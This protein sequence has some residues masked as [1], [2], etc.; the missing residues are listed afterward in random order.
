MVCQLLPLNSAGD[1]K[2]LAKLTLLSANQIFPLLQ[3]LLERTDRHP[4]LI[5]NAEDFVN[6]GDGRT[7]TE[8][9]KN[10]LN[11]YG[12]DKASKH[13]YH[14]V[15]GEILAGRGCLRYP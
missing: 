7:A 4:L 5:I 1:L 12:S 14:Y 13:N 3:E 8:E 6:S 11:S 2:S 10:L 9:L 15:Y